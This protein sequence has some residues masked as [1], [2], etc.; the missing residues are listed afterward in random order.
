V[1][2]DSWAKLRRLNA[3]REA[4]GEGLQYHFSENELL[5]DVFGIGMATDEG[6][7]GVSRR[8]V[9]AQNSATSKLRSQKKKKDRESRKQAII[10]S[11][12]EECSD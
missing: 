4:L 9:Y 11:N 1:I 8:Q 3:F 5:S 2:F 7:G 12:E 10:S 6:L